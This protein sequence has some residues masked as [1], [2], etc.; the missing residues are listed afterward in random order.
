MGMAETLRKPVVGPL[1]FVFFLASAGMSCMEATLALFVADRFGWGLK[2]VSLGF[3]Y[4]GVLATFNQGFLVRKLLPRFGE[5][6]LLRLGIVFFMISLTLIGFSQNLWL[7][8]FA[9]TLLPFGQSMTNPSILGSVSLL[10]DR[11]EQG[12]SLGDT[13]S[14]ASLG[15]IVGPALG[16]WAYGSLSQSAPYYISGLLLLIGVVTVFALGA[17]IPS[18]A[19]V[20]GA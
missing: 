4:I 14:F 9:M 1:V 17:K 12:K 11:R 20:Q 18:A 2:E 6:L 8:G 15:R 16:G 13:Q 7:L 3:V 5:R 10:S 19:K